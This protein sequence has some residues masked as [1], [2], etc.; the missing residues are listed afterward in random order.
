MPIPDRL[1][2]ARRNV[3]LT[4]AQVVE[5][6]GIADLAALE[7]GTREPACAELSVLSRL[8]YRSL[9]WLLEEGPIRG[10]VVLWCEPELLGDSE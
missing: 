10:A 9:S 5:K 8:Y 6:T 4:V 7:A 2:H 1:R 3:C